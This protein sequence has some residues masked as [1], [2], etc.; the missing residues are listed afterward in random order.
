MG[1]GRSADGSDVGR[2]AE[3]S[4]TLISLSIIHGLLELGG[5]GGVSAVAAQVGLP[6]ARVHRHLAV[7]KDAGYIV[8]DPA[9]KRYRVGWRLYLLGQSL[10]GRFDVPGLARPT[11]EELRRAVG[12]TVVLTTFTDEAVVVLEVLSGRAPVDIVLHPGVQFPYHAVAQGKVG[13]AYGPERLRETA[14]A[15]LEARTSRTVTDREALEAELKTVRERAWADAPE[16][17]FTGVNAIAAPVFTSEGEALGAIAVVGSI[18]YLPAEA[19]PDVTSAVVRAARS[20]S[21]HLGYE[22]PYPPPS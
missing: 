9:T 22:G 5:D 8:Q 21:R 19:A 18:H 6:K 13:L 20:V 7:L 17:I 16:E 12:Q 14:L 4:T 10:V 2:P 15:H 3:V 1:E 11:M